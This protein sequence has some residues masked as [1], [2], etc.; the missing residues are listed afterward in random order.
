MENIGK[1]DLLEKEKELLQK[2]LSKGKFDI[3]I[4]PERS[5]EIPDNESFKLIILPRENRDLIE[6][7]KT[8][9]GSTPR[10][11]RNTIFFLYPLES[12]RPGFTNQLKKHLAYEKILSDREIGITA[13]QKKEIQK[14]YQAFQDSVREA[15]LRLY[16]ILEVPAKQPYSIGIPTFGERKS[17]DSRV[18]DELRS[19]GEILERTTPFLIKK[20]YLEKSLYVS[21]EQIY[22]STLRTPGEPRFSSKEI[23]EEAI[24]QGIADGQFGIG[25]VAENKPQYQH[26]KERVPVSFADDEVILDPSLCKRGI[27]EIVTTDSG[28]GTDVGRKRG[29]TES[30]GG[31]NLK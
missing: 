4:W 14:L 7:I 28:H 5:I 25:M 21:T 1:D 23:L 2:N 3:Y 20:K 12:E 11:N 26:F 31:V 16:Q 13:D 15:I 27:T 10:V 18:Y 8:Q 29:G 9:K 6:D 22:L 17:L 30:K 19:S 24:S